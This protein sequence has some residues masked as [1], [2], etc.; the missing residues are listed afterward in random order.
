MKNKLP[1]LGQIVLVMQE[2]IK[3]H[4][5]NDQ[6]NMEN[7]FKFSFWDDD[8]FDKELGVDMEAFVE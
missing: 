8:D 6:L 1:F 4:L 2:C 3:K 5:K 7:D